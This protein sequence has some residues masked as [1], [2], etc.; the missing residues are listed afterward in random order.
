MSLNTFYMCIQKKATL[1]NES[2]AIVMEGAREQLLK[3][4]ATIQCI[5]EQVAF[6]VLNSNFSKGSAYC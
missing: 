6:T 4:D 1:S 2:S 3:C 5:Q